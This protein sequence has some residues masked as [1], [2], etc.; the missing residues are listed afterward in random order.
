MEVSPHGLSKVGRRKEIDISREGVRLSHVK[1]K[2][3]SNQDETDK[4]HLGKERIAAFHARGTG[5]Y[6]APFIE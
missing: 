4:P 2:G 1:K 3:S 5:N 6:A